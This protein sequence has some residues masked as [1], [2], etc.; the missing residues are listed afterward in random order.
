[1]SPGRPRS[2]AHRQGTYARIARTRGVLGVLDFVTGLPVTCKMSA[3][4]AYRVLPSPDASV[5][6]AAQHR[7]AHPWVSLPLTQPAF[8]GGSTRLT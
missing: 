7:T 4:R 2:R 3:A 8:K 6:S 1:M 5:S